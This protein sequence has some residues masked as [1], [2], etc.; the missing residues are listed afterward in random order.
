MYMY[1]LSLFTTCAPVPEMHQGPL[2]EKALS[3]DAFPDRG[4]RVGRGVGALECAVDASVPGRR[5][6]PWPT[7]VQ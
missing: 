7:V 4:A 6:A 1:I 5:C 3:L 2:G